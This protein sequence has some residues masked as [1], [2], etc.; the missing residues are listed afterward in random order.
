MPHHLYHPKKELLA[1]RARGWLIVPRDLLQLRRVDN[2]DAIPAID[3]PRHAGPQRIVIEH[4]TFLAESANE[5][6]RLLPGMDI[7]ITGDIPGAIEASTHWAPQGE[8]EGVIGGIS[9]DHGSLL[10]L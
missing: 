2:H 3:D 5:V 6:V 4:H 7:G 8:I 1:L 9:Q 10:L